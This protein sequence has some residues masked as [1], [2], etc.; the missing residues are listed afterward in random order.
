MQLATLHVNT[1]SIVL[2]MPIEDI[3]VHLKLQTDRNNDPF[4]IGEAKAWTNTHAS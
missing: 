2:D 3:H 4:L 1:T